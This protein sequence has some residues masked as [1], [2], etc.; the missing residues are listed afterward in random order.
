LSLRDLTKEKHTEAEQTPFMKAVFKK[1]LPKNLWQDFTYQKVIFYSAI[2][3]LCRKAGYFDNLPG[4]ERAGLLMKDYLEMTEDR[5]LHTPNPVAI[6]YFYY[7]MS[8]DSHQILAHFYTWHMGDL[9]GGQMIK[10]IVSD[11]PHYSLE[12]D[13]VSDLITKIRSLLTD[14]LGPEANR[15]FEFAIKLM[16]S[17]DV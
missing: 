5:F 6:E 14:D 13:N 9:H 10:K 1:T 12:F 3:N 2:E 11:A 7:L 16:N 8:L 17:Y 15:A 4:I